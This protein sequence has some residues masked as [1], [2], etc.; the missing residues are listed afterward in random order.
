[1]LLM[2]PYGALQLQTARSPA[3]G[4]PHR[5]PPISQCADAAVP[6]HLR[7]GLRRWRR[8]PAL[9]TPRT[10]ITRFP[11]AVLEVK[12]SL[13]QGEEAP[14]WIK[15]R[16]CLASSGSSCSL[17]SSCKAGAH[18]SSQAESAMLTGCVMSLLITLPPVRIGAAGERLPDGGA[19]VQQVHPRQ[20]HADARHGPGADMPPCRHCPC[21]PTPAVAPTA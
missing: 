20:R 10:E 21:I 3:R 15:V 14:E 17:Q 9:P 19:Q 1:M 5:R 8:D 2:H 18:I 6:V 7:A 13:H 16:C 11:H 4:S 12:L